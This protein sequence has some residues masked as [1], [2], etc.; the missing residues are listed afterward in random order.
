MPITHTYL[1]P[2][3]FDKFAC[4]CGQ[5]RHTCCI[6]WPIS[7][8]MNE[9][10][11]LQGLDCS[12]KLHHMLDCAF[13]IVDHPSK[14]RYAVMTTNYKGDCH[15]RLEN[16]WCGL[17]VEK[18]EKVLPSICRLYPRG[19]RSRYA[20]ECS[21]S[22]SCEKTIELLLDIPSPL[23]FVK[24][25]LIGINDK[26][27]TTSDSDSCQYYQQVENLYLSI[28]QN[29]KYRFNERMIMLG[30]AI[31]SIN[32]YTNKNNT[33]DIQNLVQ[34][35]EV[36][37]YDQSYNFNDS[38]LS[39]ALNIMNNLTLSLGENSNSI[40]EY[41]DIIEENFGMYSESEEP[42]DKIEALNIK[43]LEAR[44]HFDTIFP[45]GEIFLEHIMINHMFFETFPFSDYR[46]TLWDEYVS[47]CGVY[48]FV[49]FLL[50]GYMAKKDSKEDI[51]DLVAAAFRLIEHS[52]FDQNVDIILKAN[53]CTTLTSLEMLLKI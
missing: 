5:C 29:R 36:S 46:E 3:Y 25:E 11:I 15:M 45:E 10:F 4:K 51:V 17:Q 42:S 21:C 40:K 23:K 13:H 9:Y 32:D 33:K 27:G 34:T 35:L 53:Q 44:N 30:N 43:Y 31:K 49:R 48:S 2:E 6:G 52:S 47:L 41:C 14:E 16:G 19:Y 39:Y 12:K 37:E 50:I 7:I 18:G 20:Y 8:S 24:K 22:N 1:V 28:L 38:N 26:E